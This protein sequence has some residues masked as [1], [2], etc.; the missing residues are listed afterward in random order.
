MA[1]RLADLNRS[2]A[3]D[4]DE[5]LRMSIGIHTGPAIIGEMVYGRA[6]GL[7]AIGDTVNIASR[8]E[9]LSK[10]YGCELV[11]SEDVEHRAGLAHSSYTSHDIKIRG[12]SAPVTVR[13][14]ADATTLLEGASP[15]DIS[16]KA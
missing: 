6:V 4:M 14:I 12:R 11:V 3:N 9:T 7:T 13:V 2:L 15:G 8:L 16:T 10:E 1:S 5:P